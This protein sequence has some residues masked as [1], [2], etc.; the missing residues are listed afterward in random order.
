[1]LETASGIRAI[2]A[3]MHHI[4][5]AGLIAGAFLFGGVAA[6]GRQLALGSNELSPV[7]RVVELLQG[8][9]KQ[10]DEEAKKEEDLYETFVCWA[11]SII[12]QKTESNAAA[13]SRIDTLETYVKDL[14]AGRIELTTERADLEKEIETLRGDLEVAAELRKK[15]A[16]EYEDA[17]A[18]MD[19]AITALESALEVLQTA[20]KDKKTG[21]LLS[22]RSTLDS[23]ASSRTAEASALN[24]AVSL[25]EKVLTPG[26]T[27]FLQRLLI[28]EVPEHDWKKLNRKA[29]FK[30][31]YKARSEKIEG[32]LQKMLD[33]FK[34]NLKEATEKEEEAQAL[35]DKLNEAK[36]DELQTAEDA[37]TKMEKETGARGLSKE[38][39]EEEI[40]ALKKQVENDTK[41]ISQVEEALATKMDEWKARKELRAGELAAISKAISILHSD[42]ARDLFKKSFASQ[43]FVFLQES[44]TNGVRSEAAK[45]LREVAARASDHRIAGLAARAAAAA[46]GH[47]DE[48]IEAIDKMIATLKEEE[49]EDLEI[50]E[51]CEEDRAADTRDAIK[52]SRTMDEHTEAIEALIAKIDQLT[53][54][55]KD[56]EEQV[57]K[58]EEQLKQ[59]KEDREKEN[60][61]Y[62]VAKKDDEAAADLIK[63]SIGV[64]ESF[65]QENGLNLIQKKQDAPFASKAGEAPPPPPPTWDGGYGGKTDEQTGIVAILG[66]IREDI[67]KDIAKAD[68][69]EADAVALYEKTTTALTNEKTDLKSEITTLGE[70]KAN[71]EQEVEDHKG[72]RSAKAGELNVLLDKIKSAEPGCAF[73]QIN[74]AVR[75]SNRQMEIDGL[76]KAKTILS[77]GE[78]AK[79]EDPNRELKPGDA[80]LQRPRL[81][82]VHRVTV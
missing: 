18:E 34:S 23:S 56:K 4:A 49:A 33:T 55:I 5:R 79:P 38:E 70:T 16:S 29:T 2:A 3:A 27:R 43:G 63:Q 74:Y 41:Y 14:M 20:S 50:K 66:L 58:I 12:S 37:L 44:A 24:L 40:E 42:D 6:S 32:A 72:S 30:M 68:K 46:A 77:G 78:F 31:S 28:G 82:A 25:G 26:D 73:F 75:A 76:N 71:A 9:S 65:Y 62:E 61:E 15:E 8:L 39:A 13:K 36:G 64:L 17:K 10:I 45:T 48:V 19:Q 57:V 51:Q 11:K 52:A 35:Y 54:E 47:F 80:L 21:S 59:A 7:T 81:A 53:R 22:L 1:L 60:A 69:E 67:L